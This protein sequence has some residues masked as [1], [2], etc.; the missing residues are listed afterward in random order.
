MDKT[1]L[2]GKQ[3]A[4]FLRKV[5]PEDAAVMMRGI[6]QSIGDAAEEFA[7]TLTKLQHTY[8]ELIAIIGLKVQLTVSDKVGGEMVNF[9]IGVNTTEKKK[10]EE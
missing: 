7:N 5:G 2:T 1:V 8:P 3:V 9:S 10:K 4:E 6:R